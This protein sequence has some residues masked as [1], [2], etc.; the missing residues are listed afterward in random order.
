MTQIELNDITK[1]YQSGGGVTTRALQ[2]VTLSIQPGEMVGVMGPSG[3]GKSTL[4]N[5]I[6][7]LD[8]PSSGQ[9]WLNGQ[10]MAEINN[11]QRRS[12]LRGEKIGF[13]F[14]NFNLI[15]RAS[16]LQ[17]VELPMLYWKK[18]NRRARALFALKQVGL[19]NRAKHRPSELSGGEAQRI[20][21]AR[22]LVNDPEIILADEPTGNLD[23]KTGREIIQLLQRLNRAG[24]TIVL[25]THDLNLAK[26]YTKRII[27]LRDGEILK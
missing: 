13:V 5:I 20:A 24:K 18:K 8:R 26:K 14:Q 1:I 15:P 27:Q 22:A 10:D 9:Y 19:K 17:N 21:I 23:S 25:V 7:L 6:G 16:A 4:M 3:C 2:G 12:R 11:D